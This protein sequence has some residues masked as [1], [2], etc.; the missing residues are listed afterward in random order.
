MA[1]TPPCAR[2][3]V[4]HVPPPAGDR[5]RPAAGQAAHDGRQVVCRAHACVTGGE[6]AKQGRHVVNALHR[7]TTATRRTYARVHA[8][9]GRR[10]LCGRMHAWPP[11]QPTGSRA[12]AGRSPAGP[13]L[14][15]QRN[16]PRARRTCVGATSTGQTIG[17][18]VVAEQHVSKLGPAVRTYTREI[19][20][21]K[22]RDSF[23]NCP[24]FFS[25]KN[26]RI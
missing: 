10:A 7:P 8:A 17:S 19:V 1:S 23:K 9:P 11:P 2:A 26:F 13:G 4:D 16:R 6:G 18:V 22:S 12:A 21:I 14:H 5:C 25:I 3:Y 24:S 20:G 15:V